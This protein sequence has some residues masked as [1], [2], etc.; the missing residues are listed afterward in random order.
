MAQLNR[1]KLAALLA[2]LAIRAAREKERKAKTA[3]V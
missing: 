2:R 1:D 3:R